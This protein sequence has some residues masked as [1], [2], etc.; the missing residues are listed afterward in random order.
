MTANV[1]WEKW[2]FDVVWR[3]IGISF[4]SLIHFTLILKHAKKI[5][6][7]VDKVLLDVNNFN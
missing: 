5:G 1:S 7:F 6:I 2:L 3:E 4:L